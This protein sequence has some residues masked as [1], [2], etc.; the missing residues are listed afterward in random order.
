ML[1][2]VADTGAPLARSTSMPHTAR[3][4]EAKMTRPTRIDAQDACALVQAVRRGDER[5]IAAVL[6][7]ANVPAMARALAVVLPRAI[8]AQGTSV[9]DFLRSMIDSAIAEKNDLEKS[10]PSNQIVPLIHDPGSSP[11]AGGDIVPLIYGSGTQGR[12]EP[13]SA[14]PTHAG[15]SF[16]PEPLTETEAKALLHAPSTRAPTGLRNRALIAVLYGAGLRLAEALALK[17]SGV[18]FDAGEI[19]VLHGKGDEWRTVGI[20]AGALVHVA[21]WADYRRSLGF[22]NGPLLCTLDGKPLSPRYVR[23]MLTRMAARA[24]IDKRVHPHGLRHTHAVELEKAGFTVTEIQ[25]QLGHSSLAT[26]AVYLNHISPSA[27]VA[28]VH[29][30]RS[31]L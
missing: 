23:A 1:V 20:D 19:R 27:R 24:G 9:D 31:E 12:I 11:Q 14:P 2:N 29:N 18:D 5:A 26:T 6:T 8:R 16:P 13:M 30:R 10:P 4:P 28:K 17:A 3:K 15:Q 25:G 7:S 21:R 22:R